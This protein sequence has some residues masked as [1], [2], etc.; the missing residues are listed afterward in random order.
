MLLV[1]LAVLIAGVIIHEPRPT[2]ESGPPADELAA[3]MLSAL[4]VE[5]WDTTHYVSWTFR[6][7]NQY[8]WDRKR[9][10]VKVKDAKTEVLIHTKSLKYQVVQPSKPGGDDYKYFKSAWAN[11]CN[12]A[13]W[14]CA[15]Y[16]IF[17]SGTKRAIVQGGAADHQL[18]V[19]YKSGGITPGDTY[20]WQLDKEYKPLSFKMWV[21]IIPVGG[22][23]VSWSDWEDLASGAMVASERKLWQRFEVPITEIRGGSDWKSI[24]LS[25][26]PFSGLDWE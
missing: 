6:G 20:L 21:S 2:G 12:D 3:K 22:V 25:K 13:F 19:T 26:D 5:A 1:F 11:F 15:P 18:M 10:L 24:G 17:D 23:K 7:V 14:L 4:K 9:H 8:I 16:K